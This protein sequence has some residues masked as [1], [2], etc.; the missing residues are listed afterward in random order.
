M[1]EKAVAGFVD[2]LEDPYTVYLTTEENKELQQIL[3]EESGIEGIG[4]VIEKKENY[5]QIAEIIKN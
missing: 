3:H 2:G 5:I 4:A 1:L